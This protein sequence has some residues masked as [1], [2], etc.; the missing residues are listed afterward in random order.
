MMNLKKWNRGAILS[1]LV[2]LGVIVYLTVTGAMQN[3]E[4]PA[5]KAVCENY[6]QT[7]VG[8]KMLPEKYRT[9]TPTIPKADF[10]VYLA[11]M[12]KDI[13]AFF[14]SDPESVKFT[15]DTLTASLTAQSKGTDV[16]LRFTKKIAKYTDIL[17]E[18]DTVTVN[19]NSD[20]VYESTGSAGGLLTGE[21]QDTLILQKIGGFWKV[22]YSN[23]S[24][25]YGNMYP[26]AGKF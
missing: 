12:E 23:L 11:D 19:F 26:A 16:V 1:A 3:A 10:D 22:V 5:I 18:K 25:P 6:A 13:K 8:Y 24:V 7:E 15:L 17:F 20:N 2:L 21:T 14:P 9:V 4:K